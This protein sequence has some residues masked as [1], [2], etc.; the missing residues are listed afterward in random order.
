VRST[1]CTGG[2]F[3]SLHEVDLHVGT[4]YEDWTS[5]DRVVVGR[6]WPVLVKFWIIYL[7]SLAIA[8][9]VYELL[10]R[11]IGALRLLFDMRNKGQGRPGN[12]K[13]V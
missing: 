3:E 1:E 10:V 13:D 5:G 6:N 12:R 11:R 9:L 2:F 4:V 7:G 8:L